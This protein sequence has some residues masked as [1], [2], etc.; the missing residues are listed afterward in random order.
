MEQR[1]NLIKIKALSTAN[2][3]AMATAAIPTDLKY[4]PHH[5]T[6]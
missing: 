4:S 1:R 6:P 5:S 3:N 2:A